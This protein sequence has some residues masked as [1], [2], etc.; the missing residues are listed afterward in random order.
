ME[1]EGLTYK[2]AH[3]KAELH[4]KFY[5]FEKDLEKLEINLKIRHYE[6]VKIIEPKRK[7]G[8]KT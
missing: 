3:R 5:L 2:Q 4:E 8:K 7:R 6:P 1:T